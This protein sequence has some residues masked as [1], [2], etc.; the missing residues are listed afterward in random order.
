[1]ARSGPP[2]DTSAESEHV[3]RSSTIALSADGRSLWLTSPDDDRLVQVDAE[4]LEVEAQVPLDG[5]P[6]QLT[7]AGDRIVVTGAQRTSVAIVEIDPPAA[8]PSSVEVPCGGTKAV[9]T[10]QAAGR[11]LA[12]VTCPHDDLVAVVDIDAGRAAATVAVPGR[13][14]GIVRDGDALSVSTAGN[15]HIT[16]W[17]IARLVEDLG[18]TAA[19]GAALPQLETPPTSVTEAWV[20]GER[21]ASGLGPLD[22]ANVGVVGTYQVVDNLRKLTSAEL[23]ADATYGSPVGGRARLEPALAGPCGARFTD[24]AS[25]AERLSGPV[26][27]AAGPDDLVWVVG[28][29]D[30]RV[31]VVRCDGGSPG[32]RSSIVAAFSVGDGARGIALAPSGEVAF[33]D[34]GFDHA[35]ARLRLP[36]LE[37]ATAVDQPPP[38]IEPDAVGRRQVDGRLSPL[39]EAG[40][41]MFHD[42]TDTHLTPFGVVTCASCHPAA[43]ED[44]LTWRI[45]TA[46]IPTKL[47]RT[48]ALWGTA[49]GTPLHWAGDTTSTNDLVL[50]TVQELLGGDGLL[51]DTRAIAAY[52]AET[53]PPPAPASGSPEQAT[54]IDDGE[55]VF[56]RACVTCHAGPQGKDGS[57]HDVLSPSTDPA[58]RIEEVV[59]PM[60]SGIRGRAPFGH[61]GRAKTLTDLLATHQDGRGQPIELSAEELAAV[62]AYLRTR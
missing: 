28:Q 58:A 12:F 36:R 49:D 50:D 60:L 61:D 9:V 42:A 18:P 57:R 35:V 40:R 25:P 29:F 17:S 54:T 21:R 16:T 39:A 44:G 8:R 2:A 41:S 52:L 23:R 56:Q 51:I 62:A 10:A 26:A 3:S 6:D 20:D 37:T 31:A 38:S 15:G 13:P 19:T 43:G 47:R 45:E 4:T 32:S 27:L 53:R 30:R 48:Q 22:A 5:E 1:M 46:E 14:T 11:P 59:T 33:V 34:V 7:R 24:I 55:A